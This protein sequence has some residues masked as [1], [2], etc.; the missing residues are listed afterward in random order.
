MAIAPGFSLLEHFIVLGDLWQTGARVH[1]RSSRATRNDMHGG[2]ILRFQLRGGIFSSGPNRP[3][4][5]S[6]RL[7]LFV[8]GLAIF[9]I[10]LRRLI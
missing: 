7:I 8:G 3:I 5:K 9:A 4:S 10:G 1:E 6:G 2:S